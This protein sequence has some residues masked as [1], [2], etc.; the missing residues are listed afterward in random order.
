MA[1]IFMRRKPALIILLFLG[2]ICLVDGI[3]KRDIKEILVA[4]AILGYAVVS[5]VTGRKKSVEIKK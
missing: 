4:L 3:A 2:T 1:L 5:L